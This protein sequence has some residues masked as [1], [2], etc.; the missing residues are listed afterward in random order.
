MAKVFL[1]YASRDRELASEVFAWLRDAGHDV[2]F[3]RDRQ[4]GIELG[5]DWKP[6]CTGSCGAATP[7]RAC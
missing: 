1:S 7:S 4:R 2:F 6:G 3:D 5:E